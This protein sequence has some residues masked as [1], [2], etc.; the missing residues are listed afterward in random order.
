MPVSRET[1]VE[2]IP[3]ETLLASASELLGLRLSAKQIDDLLFYLHQLHRWNQKINLVG[4][5][6][7][8]YYAV[9]H[10][11]DSLALIKFIDSGPGTIL[12][13]GSGGGFP[14]L[15]LKIYWPDRPMV[16][17]ESR[18]KKAVF[19][20]NI[21]RSFNWKNY[22][23]FNERIENIASDRFRKPI[24]LI[25]FRAVGELKSILPLLHGI[26][27]DRGVLVAYKGP[28]WNRELMEAET[29]MRETGL[30]FVKTKLYELPY[31]QKSR[32]L[33][34]FSK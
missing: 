34:F 2:M 6:T 15:V 29:V 9:N 25:T 22:Q 33:L 1:E 16:L 13:F 14:G 5:G 26:L 7:I 4:P 21:G 27:P 28:D 23:I 31:V 30:K 10:V 32:S 8:N 24:E 18:Q 20:K 11:I 17:V 12:D 3:T 19:L